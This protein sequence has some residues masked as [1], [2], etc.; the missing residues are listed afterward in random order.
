MK[1]WIIVIVGVLWA[2]SLAAGGAF[3]YQAG[4]GPCRDT[5]QNDT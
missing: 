5:G 2:A 4:Q 1:P 3:A